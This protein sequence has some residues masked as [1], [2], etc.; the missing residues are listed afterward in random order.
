MDEFLRRHK[1]AKIIKQEIEY[2][3][4]DI[5]IKDIKSILNQY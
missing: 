2:L 3:I 4:E 1:L 5:R